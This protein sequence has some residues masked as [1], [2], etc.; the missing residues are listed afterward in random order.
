MNKKI[1][2]FAA[3]AYSFIVSCSGS[4]KGEEIQ[5]SSEKTT[6]SS[7]SEMAEEQSDM[8][9][10]GE[11]IALPEGGSYSTQSISGSPT[12]WFK[13]TK[14]K[15]TICKTGNGCSG[16]WGIYH[17]NGTYEGSCQ[18]SDGW[19]HK[20]GHGPEKHGLKKF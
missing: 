12:K 6:I 5:A 20:C 18:N 19:G 13:K 17:S 4:Q 14:N 11:S 10:N 2:F 8:K 3:V 9:I 15:C 1:L 7:K 16:Y